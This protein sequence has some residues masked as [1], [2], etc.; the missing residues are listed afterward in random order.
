MKPTLES[1]NYLL[2]AARATH[3]YGAAQ[4]IWARMQDDGI[5]PDDR[6]LST[7]F[8]IR[9][10]EGRERQAMEIYDRVRAQNTA[11]VRAMIKTAVRY[12]LGSWLFNKDC[13]S[14][15]NKPK[16]YTFYREAMD[17]NLAL[18]NQIH[19][20]I[21][22]NVAYDEA[23]GNSI[24]P[25]DEVPR[26]AFTEYQQRKEGPVRSPARARS[27]ASREVPSAGPVGSG[28]PD[29][30]A[31]GS[32]SS[33]PASEAAAGAAVNEGRAT[34]ADRAQVLTGDDGSAVGAAGAGQLKDAGDR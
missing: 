1:Y 9:L 16:A 30:A 29:E 27:E 13:R 28:S 31:L 15:R 33:A 23:N 21:R 18:P 6:I 22:R 34:T 3:E 2:Q 4:S 19:S 32:A 25:L 7:L 12:Y 5:E 24:A 26:E 11:G 14:R 8:S 20:L 17:L 10:L